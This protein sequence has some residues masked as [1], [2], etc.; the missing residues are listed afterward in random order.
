ML[1]EYKWNQSVWEQKRVLTAVL[2][3]GKRVWLTTVWVRVYMAAT[4]DFTCKH[5]SI[6]VKEILETV[7]SEE[8]LVRKLDGTENLPWHMRLRMIQL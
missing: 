1:D 8:L 6:Y 7:S 3:S 4:R 5:S 2:S